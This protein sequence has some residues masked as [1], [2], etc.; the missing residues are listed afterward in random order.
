MSKADHKGHMH[1]GKIYY[2]KMSKSS[3]IHICSLPKHGEHQNYTLWLQ[4]EKGFEKLHI[5]KSK[6]AIQELNYLVD[7]EFMDENHKLL[8]T[9]EE[10]LESSLPSDNVMLANL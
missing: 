9:L 2:N 4:S 8:I 3:V 7:R 6:E 5:F 10:G 1:Y